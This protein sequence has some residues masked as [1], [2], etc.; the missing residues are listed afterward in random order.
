MFSIDTWSLSQ[1]LTSE[2]DAAIGISKMPLYRVSYITFQFRL[3][4]GWIFDNDESDDDEDLE[5]EMQ[6]A[7]DILNQRERDL[8]EQRL[9]AYYDNLN[10]SED[11]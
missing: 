3:K 10:D 11:L 9:N 2:K 7:F 4:E 8:A 6:N 5:Q 1:Y